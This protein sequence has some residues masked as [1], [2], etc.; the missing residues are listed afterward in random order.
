[1]NTLI[2]IFD[3]EIGLYLLLEDADKEVIVSGIT[4][5]DK[6]L[7]GSY[8]GFY[9]WLRNNENSIIGVNFTPMNKEDRFILE[10]ISNFKYTNLNNKGK[11]I[12][13]YFSEQK[14]YISNISS[15]QDFGYIQFL[16]SD[17]NNYAMTIDIT[18]LNNIEIDSIK[19]NC[20]A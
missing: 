17:N 10:I 14:Q 12:E 16:V 13:I 18:Q 8:I 15:D 4:Y 9:D 19:T 1:M 11:A 2:I 7:L 20:N 6:Y 5:K 3:I